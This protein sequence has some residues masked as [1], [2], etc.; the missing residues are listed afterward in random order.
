[1]RLSPSITSFTAGQIQKAS[2]RSFCYNGILI[3]HVLNI[4]YF[5][6]VM[7]EYEPK[8]EVHFPYTVT[9]ARGTT[10]RMECFALGK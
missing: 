9:A 5:P 1:M 10:V 8:I 6:G 3:F 2:H 4:L 7:G